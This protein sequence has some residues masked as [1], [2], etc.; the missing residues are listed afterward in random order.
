LCDPASAGCR[1]VAEVYLPLLLTSEPGV[2][3]AHAG[4]ALTVASIGRA[5]GSWLL[6]R[7]LRKLRANPEAGCIEQG[8]P[9]AGRRGTSCARVA[10]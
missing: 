3:P 8:T 1:F 9:N 5:F 6:G 7:V 4:L 2:R 10:G